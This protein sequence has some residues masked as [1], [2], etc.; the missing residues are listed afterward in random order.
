MDLERLLRRTY[1]F[2]IEVGAYGLEEGLIDLDLSYST[3]LA[4]FTSF[5]LFVGVIFGGLY[6]VSFDFY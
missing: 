4:F 5:T 1:L 3:V 2:S 6:D